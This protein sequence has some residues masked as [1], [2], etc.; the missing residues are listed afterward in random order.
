MKKSIFAAITLTTSL[1]AYSSGGT[2]KGVIT[3]M[4]VNNGWTMVSVPD[5]HTTI[6]SSKNNPDS[7]TSNS[8]YAIIP[9]NP[10]YTTIHATLMAA[11]MAGKQ[12]HFWVNG[13]SGQNGDYPKIVSVW[14]T[15]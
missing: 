9:S 4:Y 10:N 7:C 2:D 11:Q 1:F 13:C 6:K 8:Y 5:L 12:V 15:S 3:S 14:V